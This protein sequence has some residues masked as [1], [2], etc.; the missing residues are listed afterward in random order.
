MSETTGN[1]LVTVAT[2]PEPASAQVALSALEA[3]GISGFLQGEN[4]NGL[5][6]VAFTA[7]LLV[8][9]EDEAAA[10]EVLGAQDASLEEVTAAELAGEHV[11]D[12]DLVE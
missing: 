3:A 5:I 2:Y 4:A 8:R 6:P 10:L 9:A 11:A 7:R 1:N 12:S